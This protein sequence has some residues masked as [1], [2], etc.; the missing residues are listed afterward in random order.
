MEK[1][2]AEQTG[3]NCPECGSP[4]VKRNGR[5][6][7]F[8]ACSNYPECKYIKKE[9]VQVKEVGE[10]PNCGGK[11]VEKKS[12]KGKIFYGCANYP[13]C[14]T[15]YWY[16]PINRMCPECNNMLLDKGKKIICS[17]CDYEEDK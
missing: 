10:C 2:E 4:L 6:G 15:A 1:K 9:E 14:K 12:H 5:Y 17:N 16:I 3:E 13:K 7:E 8:I 11:I